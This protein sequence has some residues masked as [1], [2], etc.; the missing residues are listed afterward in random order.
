[1]KDVLTIIKKEFTRFF[2]DRRMVMSVILPGILIFLL[3][4]VL[5]SVIGKLADSDSDYRPSVYV[6]NTPDEL[7]D[8]LPLL[9]TVVDG[10]YDEQTAKDKVKAGELDLLVV[11]PENFDI[12]GG[13]LEGVPNVK[14][15]Y[16]SS[17]DNSL[18]GYTLMNS[19]LEALQKPSFSI[20]NINGTEYDLASDSDIAVK[21]LSTLVPMLMFALLAAA[22]MTVT[23]ESIAGE[24]E[25]GTMA[26]LL[27]T[28]VKRWQLALGKILSLS[29][30]AMLSGLS[31]FLG[32]MLSLPKLM[33]GL[34]DIDSIPYGV[35]DYFAIF[36]LIISVVLIIVSA[37]SVVSA[38]AKS[39]K[40]A[41]A[42][43]GPLMIVIILLGMVSMFI[44]DAVLGLYAIPLLGSGLALGSIMS[45][46]IE[47]AAFALSILSNLVFTV[48]FTVLLAFM[49][50]SEKIMFNK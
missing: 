35:G 41:G 15:F 13:N 50:R 19:V 1:M 9:F 43:M 12:D 3:Y 32:V 21:L 30:F 8:T 11:F 5:G 23:P 24:K 37:F 47:P 16:D 36:A 31:S 4:S 44:P 28:P 34:V 48:G 6:I 22:C 10:D 25:R 29:C 40:E 17:R 26:T 2:K 42:M 7:N 27:I 46:T 49:F 18:T 14:L 38:F 39:V 45:L 33:N 20:N